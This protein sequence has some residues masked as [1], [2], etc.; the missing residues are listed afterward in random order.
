MDQTGLRYL[1]EISNLKRRILELEI[2][3][4]SKHNHNIILVKDSA[5]DKSLYGGIE[6][7]VTRNIADVNDTVG[8]NVVGELSVLNSNN[9]VVRQLSS[10]LSASSLV[11]TVLNS[12]NKTSSVSTTPPISVLNNTSTTLRGNGFAAVSVLRNSNKSEVVG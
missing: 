5:S 6:N 9:L 2:E 11:T 1:I 4:E 8:C 10:S 3:L 12:S 7:D